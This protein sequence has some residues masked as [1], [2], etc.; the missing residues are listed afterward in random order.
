MIWIAVILF[1][2]ILAWDVISDYRKWLI[3]RAVDHG[4]EAW[5]RILLMI[6]P[7][8][9]FC[10]AHTPQFDI[11]VLTNVGFMQFFTF[12]LLFDGFYNK[13]RGYSW[14]FA[15]SDDADDPFLDDLI[16]KYPKLAAILKVAGAVIFITVY[17]LT[18]AGRN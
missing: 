9:F 6:V 11:W 18:Y 16:Q 2:A 5:L 3:H 12:W 7:T 10:I 8:V 17:I 4:A 15:G 14:W 13:L 1:F